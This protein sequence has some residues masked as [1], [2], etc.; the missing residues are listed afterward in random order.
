MATYLQQKQNELT[1]LYNCLEF[2]NINISNTPIPLN[3]IEE[4]ELDEL[5]LEA[6]LFR[7]QINQIELFLDS[8]NRTMNYKKELI[9]V[10]NKNTT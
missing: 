2:I 8:I 6:E 9:S 3:G 4:F 1:N 5:Y 10:C 7:E